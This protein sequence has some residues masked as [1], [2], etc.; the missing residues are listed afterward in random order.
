MRTVCIILARSGSKGITRKN[1]MNFCGKPLIY[2]SIQNALDSKLV[3]DVYVSTD[4]K[5]IKEYSEKCGTIVIDR[6]VELATDTVESDPSLIHALDFMESPDIVVNLQATSP[7]REA[8]DIDMAIQ[9]FKESDFDSLF[10]ATKLDDICLW[11]DK[12]E[13]I[14]FDY[15]KRGRRQDRKPFYWENGSIFVFTPENLKKYKNRMGGNIGMFI[16]PF[17]KSFQIDDPEDVS[18]AEYFMKKEILKDLT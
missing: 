1:M 6:P 10:S 8:N 4:S 7:V 17:S 11:N 13:S 2:W 16:M 12:M 14:S 15:Q 3:D 18:I 9:K 5:E